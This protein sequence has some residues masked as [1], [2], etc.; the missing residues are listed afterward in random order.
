MSV[1]LGNSGASVILGSSGG[2][3]VRRVTTGTLTNGESYTI[4]GSGF[5]TRGDYGG[6]QPFLCAAYHGFENASTDGGGWALDG[7]AHQWSIETGSRY[8]GSKTAKKVYIDT[9]YG[10]LSHTQSGTTGT[11]FAS[12]WMRVPALTQSGKFFR[13]YADAPQNNIY[14]STG[15]NDTY[16]NT[17]LNLRGFS[18][19][20]TAFVSPDPTVNWTSSTDF[21]GGTWARVDIVIT[22]SP[23][24]FAVYFNGTLLWSKSSGV[25]E[26][27]VYSTF[28]ANGHTVHW[29]A[30]LDD[31]TRAPWLHADGYNEFDDVYHDYT[32]QRVELGDAATWGTCTIREIQIPTAWEDTSIT[33][34]A[35]TGAITAGTRY[36]YVIGAD[37]VPVSTDGIPVTV[38]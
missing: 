26:Q 21:V 32:L 29:A 11:F 13:I 38:A 36:L 14:L 37:N 9:E 24:L 20:D 31:A 19:A 12:A 6:A 22:Q 18:E 28:G 27:W 3:V 35:N 33:I 7:A 23:D 2:G 10:S 34:T 16:P 1:L 15:G 5:G 4:S 8:T 17:D 25:N 30:A